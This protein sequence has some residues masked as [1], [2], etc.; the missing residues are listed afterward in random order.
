MAGKKKEE[1]FPITVSVP[2]PLVAIIDGYAKKQK[3]KRSPQ[4]LMW[5]EEKIQDLKAK[6]EL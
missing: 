6:G 4:C 3:R 2:L 1:T 5:I